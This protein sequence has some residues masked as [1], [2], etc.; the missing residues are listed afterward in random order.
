MCTTPAFQLMISKGIYCSF[1]LGLGGLFF[2]SEIIC[3]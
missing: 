2:L 3:S 1:Q